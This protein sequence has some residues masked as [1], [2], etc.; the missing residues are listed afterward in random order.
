M[1]LYKK[2]GIGLLAL[3]IVAIGIYIISGVGTVINSVSN[4]ITFSSDE[5]INGTID[6]HFYSGD[7]YEVTHNPIINGTKSDGDYY[8][9][10][11]FYGS[12]GKTNG[13][14]VQQLNI[15]NGNG[16]LNVP[17]N[18]QIIAFGSMDAG[19]S[20]S[21]YNVIKYKGYKGTVD[22]YGH[23]T[24]VGGIIF[25]DGKEVPYSHI[26]YDGQKIYLV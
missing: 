5:A 23:E 4:P 8:N 16:S 20:V 12:S 15:V 22:Y 1:K 7:Q 6:V 25:T 17:Y 24:D 10:E 3:I 11:D 9:I 18:A 2:I 14:D 21:F 13:G 19:T 26:L